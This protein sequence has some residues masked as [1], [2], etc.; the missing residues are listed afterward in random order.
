ME[1]WL[2]Q[3]ITNPLLTQ[4]DVA[5]VLADAIGHRQQAGDWNVFEFVIMPTHVHLFCEIGHR[6]LKN[7]MEDFKRWTAHRAMP[8]ID[9]L[10][11]I[12]SRKE[13]RLWQREWFDH[14]SRS[15]EED[16]RI[17]RYIRRNPEAAK[18]V[19]HWEQWRFGSW[20]HR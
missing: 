14:W 19:S 15:D 17:V 3:A 7:V 13:P 6:G 18:L 4:P 8:L 5:N 12:K 9:N 1:R 2:D 10:A 11:P 20:S 16:D